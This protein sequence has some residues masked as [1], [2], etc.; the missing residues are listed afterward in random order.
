MLSCAAATNGW[1]H[2]G[3]ALAVMSPRLLEHVPP[4][5]GWMGASDPFD[6]DAI[7]LSM[8]DDARRY[9]V[10]DVD[11]SVACLTAAMQQLLNVGERSIEAHVD[12][13]ANALAGGGRQ[14]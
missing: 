12:R 8:A 4:M 1:G 14:A 11:A 6:F 9:A 2:G 13:L 7:S 3:V 5:T 10:D